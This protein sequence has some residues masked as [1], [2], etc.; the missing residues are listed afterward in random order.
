MRNAECGRKRQVLA[1]ALALAAGGCA[2]VRLAET[3]PK[4]KPIQP[5][6]REAIEQSIQRG[7]GFLL[8]S[9]SKDGSWGSA[10]RT[11]GLNIYAPV[12]GSHQAFRAAVTAL[13]V[14]A[15]IEVGDQRP[16]VA[17]AI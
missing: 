2:R 5:P 13:C 16:E 11:K 4:P 14:S 6:T 1:L 8:A 17:W 9:Q 7:V 10:R 12:P 3:G 15:L